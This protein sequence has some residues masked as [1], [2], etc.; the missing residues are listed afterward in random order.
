MPLN[1][2]IIGNEDTIEYKD[3]LFLKS[4]FENQISKKLNGE[5]LM[6]SNATLFGYQVKDLDIIVMGN[7]ERNKNPIINNTFINDFCFV[8]ET[9]NH[10]AEDIVYE[11]NILKVK[12]SNKYH[13]VTTQNEKQKYSLKNYFEDKLKKS[14]FICNFIWLRQM[15]TEELDEL[16]E[17]NSDNN[18]LPNKFTVNYLFK[19]AFL[20]NNP[21]ETKL[22]RKAFS[23][24]K[25]IKNFDLSDIKSYFELFKKSK[26]GMSNLT[27]KKLE[28]ITKKI[29]NDQQY[30][31][32]IG[33]KTLIVSGRAGTGKTIKIMRIACDLA[34]NSNKR[35]LILTYNHALVGDIKRLFALAEIPDK[36]DNYTVN[37]MTLHKFFYELLIGFG[38]VK[39]ED[40]PEGDVKYIPDY[41]NKYDDYLNELYDYIDQGLIQDNDIQKIMKN[42]HD[43]VAW[44]YVLIDEGQ[45]WNENEKFILYRLFT[46]QKLIVADGVDQL[47]RKKSKCNWERGKNQNIDAHKL[48]EKICLRQKKN[49]VTFVNS[50]AKKFK[51]NWE[52]D[53]KE[54]LTGGKIIISTKKYYKDLH[55]SEFE[56]CKQDGNLA[57]DMIFFTSPNYV[58]IVGKDKYDK[59]IK[60]FSLTKEFEN[61]GIKI[62]DGTKSDLRSEYSFNLNEFRV[63]QYDSCRGLEGWTVV[64]LELDE[65]IRYK[66]ETYE[67]E[68]D[69]DTL[70]L[71]SEEEKINNY[72]YLWSLIPLTRAID[73][74]VITIKNKNS[75]FAYKLK[76]IYE[77]NKDFIEWI[78]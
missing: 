76:E 15:T 30:V 48:Y 11:N 73:T 46:P 9:K 58:K 29:L 66:S 43:Q 27:R 19:K 42:R 45:D 72:V 3:T 71:I 13:D 41:L 51:L 21:Y 47:I 54:E 23:C 64:C 10:R 20:Q 36:I 50:Y 31:P 59:D 78:E 12:Y 17:N 57:F 74:L 38:I 1:I 70:G 44:D 75:E 60:E 67:P 8:I 34:I 5:I 14:P 7:F 61:M 22:N 28:V 24:A 55:I 33:T 37:I 56:K 25:K 16:T 6:I 68:I 2:N 40:N 69:Y 39:N 4:I 49:L 63:L 32:I 18:I 65:F 77:N 53:I 26:A 52:L 62:W 35:C